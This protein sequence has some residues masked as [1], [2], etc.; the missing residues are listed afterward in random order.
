MA[1]HGESIF[2]AL[3]AACAGAALAFAAVA[4]ALGRS[5]RWKHLSLLG[6]AGLGATAFSLLEGST[7]T[8]TPSPAVMVLEASASLLVAALTLVALL[9]YA[10]EQYG[11]TPSAAARWLERS[12]LVVAASTLVPGLCFSGA[13]TRVVM[14]LKQSWPIATPVGEVMAGVIVVASFAVFV[15]HSLVAKRGVAG[16][17]IHAVGAGILALLVVREVALLVG[18]PGPTLVH[19]GF[20][21]GLLPA[22]LA[23]GLKLARDAER[24]M[25]KSAELTEEVE[26]QAAEL[27][28]AREHLFRAERLAALGTLASSVGHE[29]NNP[30][31]AVVANL[32]WLATE[33]RE[34][35]SD[36]V[37]AAI[38]ESRD[39]AQRIERIVADMRVFG[40]ANEGAMRPVAVGPVLA[41]ALRLAE[42][43]VRH[44]ATLILRD[45]SESAL[46]AVACDATKLAQVVVNLVVNA[47]YATAE[48]GRPS[49]TP[50]RVTTR[51]APDGWVEIA[52]ADEG[53][54]MSPATQQR[55]FEPFFT[56]KGHGQG[57]GLGLYVSLGIVRSFGGELSV[58]SAEGVGTTMRMRLPPSDAAPLARAREESAAPAASARTSVQDDSVSGLSVLVVEDDPEVAASLRRMLAGATVTVAES[59]DSAVEDLETGRYDVVLCDLMLPVLT[60][61]EVFAAAERLDAR[62]AR[63]FLFMTGGPVTE[64]ARR[65]VELHD[66]RVLAKP[67][68]SSLL[69]E[70]IRDVATQ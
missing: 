49:S 10:Y 52:V 32:D 41:S 27:V 64:D 61:M 60:G 16:A 28:R 12:L 11:E 9:R 8:H 50:V 53:A 56:T 47:A 20:S 2:A 13:T 42:H 26:R 30:L 14:G 54:G 22:M 69:R 31:T 55:L 58:E 46:P 23:T 66:R 40:R 44:R 18:A 6:W 5:Q 70:R 68:D 35:S 1:P 34:G 17:W 51:R 63:R 29:V 25:I 19:L 21:L 48:A 38:D 57:T 67:F 62:L 45:E 4:F 15:R 65:F 7:W 33:V 59:G 36:A 3:A 37:R 43:S 39:A 24:L